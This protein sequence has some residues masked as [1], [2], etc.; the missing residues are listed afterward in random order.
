MIPWVTG[1]YITRSFTSS[2]TSLCCFCC[3]CCI[4]L[5]PLLGLS[6]VYPAG[7]PVLIV[8]LHQGRDLLPAAVHGVN[9]T[10]AEGAAGRQIDE[11]RGQ[12][13][14]GHELGLTGLVQS[15]HRGKQANSV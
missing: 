13:L 10:R 14:D 15:G 5:L 1:K 9:T 4:K 2:R 8:H 6:N 12:A 3:C 7:G 11:G